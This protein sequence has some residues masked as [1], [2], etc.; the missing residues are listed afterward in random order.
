M[1]LKASDLVFYSEEATIAFY[2][3]F[4]KCGGSEEVTGSEQVW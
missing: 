3:S 2:C 1:T 4:G